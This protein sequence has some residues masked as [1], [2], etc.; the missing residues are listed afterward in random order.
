MDKQNIFLLSNPYQ[1]Y[2]T[3]PHPLGISPYIFGKANTTNIKRRSNSYD[4]NQSSERKNRREKYIN[5]DNTEE[6]IIEKK[7]KGK[8]AAKDDREKLPDSF[9]YILKENGIENY[10]SKVDDYK[11]INLHKK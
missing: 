10:Y 11:S 8:K 6:S 4:A 3:N 5:K 2:Q 7:K 9:S 1:G